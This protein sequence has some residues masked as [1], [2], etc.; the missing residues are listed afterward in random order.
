M[1]L[2]IIN[3]P[4]LDLLGKREPGTYGHSSLS[5]IIETLR[6]DFPGHRIDHFQSNVEGELINDLHRAD[7]EYDAVVLNA[8]GYN[9]TSVA[10]TD[11]VAGIDVPVL[12]VHL[13][14]IYAREEFRRHSLLSPN[15]IGS[16]CGLG[17]N[18]YHLAVQHFTAQV[19]SD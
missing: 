8:G 1:K 2:I 13:S 19:K 9:H 15:C 10:L 16:I 17:A 5:S 18:V 12:E 6:K 7:G 14:N 11:A 3:G 4:N